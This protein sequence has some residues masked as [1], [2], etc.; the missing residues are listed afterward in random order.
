[1]S[2]TQNTRHDVAATSNFLYTC[3]VCERVEVA[4]NRLLN[5]ENCRQAYRDQHGHGCVLTTQRPSVI[6]RGKDPLQRLA[7]KAWL[8]DENS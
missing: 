8:G 2:I 1:M 5:C 4:E 6:Y 7:E 3:G